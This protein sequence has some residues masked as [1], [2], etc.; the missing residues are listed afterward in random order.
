M[1]IV[2]DWGRCNGNGLC[3]GEAPDL[4]EIQNNGDLAVLNDCPGEDQRPEAESAVQLCP[5]EALKI[6]EDEDL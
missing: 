5:T 2:V 1:R 4:F 3:E 6:E